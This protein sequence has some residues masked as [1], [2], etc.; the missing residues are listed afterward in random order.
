MAKRRHSIRTIP[1]PRNTLGE[2][3]IE[4][5]GKRR[6][7]KYTQATKPIRRREAPPAADF[8]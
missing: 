3:L 6:I 4:V 7:S 1:N 2:K 8:R 5:P